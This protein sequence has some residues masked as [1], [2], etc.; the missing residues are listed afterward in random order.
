MVNGRPLP[1]QIHGNVITNTFY[2]NI[3]PLLDDFLSNDGKSDRMDYI[4][5]HSVSGYQPN[6]KYQKISKILNEVK[7]KTGLEINMASL[8]ADEIGNIAQQINDKTDYIAFKINGKLK[9]FNKVD[10]K[11]SLLLDENS[12]NSISSLQLNHNGDASFVIKNED[13][14]EVY[15]A[16]YYESEEAIEIF[17]SKGKESTYVLTDDDFNNIHKTLSDNIGNIH[18][19]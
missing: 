11:K 18:I 14:G 1:Y 3:Q 15:K 19:M 17:T 12:V 5:R 16:N 6:S 13:T 8:G 7:Q 2:G 9:I 10:F 4:H